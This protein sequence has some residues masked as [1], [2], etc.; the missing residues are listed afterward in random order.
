MKFFKYDENKYFLNYFFMVVLNTEAVVRKC[1]V[2]E[3]LLEISQNSQE[4]T[5]V[6]ISFFNSLLKRRLWHM[7]FSKNFAKFLAAPFL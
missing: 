6:R 5:C 4:N 1:S 2:K 3:V 7:Y